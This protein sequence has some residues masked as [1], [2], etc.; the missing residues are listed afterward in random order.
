[1][2]LAAL[3]AVSTLAAAP[4]LAQTTGPAPAGPTPAA[5][6]PVAPPQPTAAA[7]KAAEAALKVVIDEFRAGKPDY[8]GMTDELRDR[9]TPKADQMHNILT[10]LGAVK[11]VSLLGTDPDSGVIFF[12]V[13]FEHAAYDWA[14]QLAPDGKLAALALRP[15]QTMG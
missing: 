15:S 12:R 4:A 2:K 3:L 13:E 7:A 14:I 1:M 6:D 5:A 8:A 10:G 9:I 11:T